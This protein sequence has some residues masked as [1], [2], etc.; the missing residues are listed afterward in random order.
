M[1][2]KRIALKLP[3]EGMAIDAIARFTELSVEPS[4]PLQSSQAQADYNR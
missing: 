3:R 1:S 2:P 4:Q